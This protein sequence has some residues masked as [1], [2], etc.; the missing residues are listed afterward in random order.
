MAGASQKTKTA[1]GA[2][3]GGGAV[4]GQLE[5]AI[6]DGAN[7]SI[8]ATDEKGIIRSFNM[9]AE[10]LLGYRA[11]EVVDRESI[12]IIHDPDDVQVRTWHLIVENEEIIEPGFDVLVANARRGI[13][14]EREWIYVRKDGGRFPV[15]L[16]I[17]ALL[18]RGSKPDG[19]VHIA[20]DITKEKRAQIALQASEERFELIFESSPTGLLM[21]DSAGAIEMLNVPVERMFGYCREELIGCPVDILLPQSLRSDH[22]RLR[23]EYMTDQAPRSMGVGREMFGLTKNGKQLPLEVGLTPMKLHGD[24]FVLCSVVDISERRRQEERLVFLAMHDP[25]THLANRNALAR[26]MRHVVAEAREGKCSSLIY[27]DMDHFKI[28]NDTLGHAA[29]DRLLTQVAQVLREAVRKNDVVARFGGDEFVALLKGSSMVDAEMIG[30]RIL[31]E[32]EKLTFQEGERIFRVG[33]SMGLMPVDGTLTEEQIMS[34][35]D[36]ACY[37]AK[38][39]GRNRLATHSMDEAELMQLRQDAEWIARIKEAMRLG[40]LELWFQPIVE[41]A[42]NQIVCYEVLVRMNGPGG[43]CLLPSVFMEAVRR[44]GLTGDLDRYVVRESLKHLAADPTLSLSINLFAQSLGDPGLSAFLWETFQVSRVDPRRV[45][46]EITETEA[47]SNLFLAQNLIKELKQKGYR[48]ALDDIGSGFS[49]M[50]YMRRLS[51][52]LVKF[53]AEFMANLQNDEL[54]RIFIRATAEM[55]RFLK[56]KCVAEYVRDAKTLALV[57]ELG[58]DYAQGNYLGRPGRRSLAVCMGGMMANGE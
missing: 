45:I 15:R 39:R 42:S 10:R 38:T 14:D 48:F 1:R 3:A 17:T 31:A 47:I 32:V 18:G 21:V 54:D 23:K 24:S 28:I 30:Q 36:A 9:A 19:Y 27:L 35:A 41:L 57:R 33:A 50:G 6:L 43:E 56:I 53:G 7:Y 13:P 11:E 49:S 46:I 40:R 51:I 20:Y 2:D 55:A 58:I 8:I 34:R 52:D 4:S 37:Q 22:A 25:L 16:S 12:E 29:G 26:E 44:G 5:K